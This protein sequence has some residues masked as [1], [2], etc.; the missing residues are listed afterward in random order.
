MSNLQI[1]W[2]IIGFIVGFLMFI[3]IKRC[4]ATYNGL[5]SMLTASL[6][7]IFNV[8]YPFVAVI[9]AVFFFSYGLYQNQHK[10]LGVNN[11]HGKAE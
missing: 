7:G 9:I 1:G 8:S 5:L 2:I 10:F 4:F 11:H 6:M 3:P